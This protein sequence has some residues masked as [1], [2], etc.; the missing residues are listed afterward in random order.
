[1]RTKAKKRTEITLIYV[2]FYE[3]DIKWNMEDKTHI[4]IRM[5][6]IHIWN[7]FIGDVEKYC[8]YWELAK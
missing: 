5:G 1:M 2:I 4:T 6:Y 7:I 8:Y 3:R